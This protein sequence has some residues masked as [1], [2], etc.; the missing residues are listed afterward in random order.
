MTRA[1]F[2]VDRID[3]QELSWEQMTALIDGL[4]DDHSS[5]TFA[6]LAGW[7]YVPTPEEVAF[8]ND[9]DVKLSMNRGK[10]Q[11]QPQPVKRPWE[12]GRARAVVPRNDPE[13]LKRRQHLN[14]R[15]GLQ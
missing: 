11:P 9:L 14:E 5:H 12:Q 1:G 15:L 4:V 3:R 13:T 7:S 6:S 10:N 2:G 8:Y